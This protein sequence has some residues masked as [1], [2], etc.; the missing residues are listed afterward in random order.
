MNNPLAPAMG[1]GYFSALSR[2]NKEV[3]L[4]KIKDIRGSFKIPLVQAKIPTKAFVINLPE[5]EDRW[6]RFKVKNDLL[7]QKF[8]VERVDGVI[9]KNAPDGIFK[10]HLT[11]MEKS[12]SLGE[13]IMVF[14][15]DCELAEG[16]VQKLNDVFKEVPEDW[17]VIIGN[18]YFF[19]QI[20]VISDHLAKPR[21][22]ASTAN[23]VI[24]HPR[25]Y[26]KVLSLAHLRE[27]P[28]IKDVDHFL[29]SED[30]EVNNYTIW[31]MVS[32]EFLSVS[33]HYQKVRNMEFRIREHAH[34]FQFIDSD[35]YYPTIESW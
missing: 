33:D 29:T 16:W 15:D 8:N 30:I 12:R 1:P 7:F 28:F 22:K 6:A 20:D 14:E 18:H 4:S 13:P 32:R 25:C 5:R 17:D 23:F 27:N 10:A 9:E 26:E 24:Y 21:I 3:D 34:Q 11:C 35:K 2:S 31:P 19:G